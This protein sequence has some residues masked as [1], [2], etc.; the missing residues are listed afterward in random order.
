MSPVDT[1]TAVLLVVSRLLVQQTSTGSGPQ[2][3]HFREE[4]VV[5]PERGAEPR[6]EVAAAVSVLSRPEIE[7]LPAENLAE[8]LDFLPG[9]QVLFAQGFGLVPMVLSRGFFGGGEAEYVQLLIDGVPVADVESGIAD[10]RRVRAADVERV[11]ALRGPGSSL[12]GDA[13]LGGVVQ[14]FTRSAGTRPQGEVSLSAA[15]FDSLSL[16]ALYRGKPDP[17][18]LGFIGSVSRTDGFRRHSAADERS[19][20]ATLGSSPPGRRWSVSLSGSERARE[21]PGP[22]SLRQ[23]AADRFASDPLFRFDREK[24]RRGRAAFALGQ[25]QEQRSF[26]VLVHGTTR[27]T[28]FL[29]TLLIGA[30]VGDRAFRTISTDSVGASAEAERLLTAWGRQ[31][32]L[33]AG[34]DASHEWLRTTYSAV[35]E[36]GVRGSEIANGAGRRDRLAVFVSQDGRLH[37]RLRL[38][39]GLRWDR[40]QDESRP[41]L[42]R[43]HPAQA[44]SPRAGLNLRLGRADRPVL[45]FVQT[46]RAFK[47]ATLDQLL[48]PR[49]FPDF[50]GGTFRISNPTLSPQRAVTLEG[51]LSFRSESTRLEALVYRTSVKDEIDFD[52]STFR[53]NNIGRSRHSG[54]EASAWMGEGRSVSS[55]LSYVWTRV[56][57]LQEAGRGRQLKN[58]PRHLVRLGTTGRLPAGLRVEACLTWSAGRYLDDENR[59][60][61]RNASVVEL[62]LGRSFGR[63]RTRVDLMNL[64]GTE[65]EEVGYALPDFRGGSV[66]YF[67]P[68]AG[69]AVRLGLDWRFR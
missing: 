18:R 63:F 45:L 54:L 41:A 33:R 15:S 68:S 25:E 50:A 46:S 5:T 2:S 13:A 43:A 67:F 20:D 17:V 23:L 59:I 31:G 55:R 58:I 32:R 38:V 51:G 49:P 40:I 53:Y 44:F 28:D 35:S 29:R 37:P 56:E 7:R 30:G 52:P 22:L 14:V 69:R 12:Y 19:A 27:D 6:G 16:D 34:L 64:T 48:D 60:P 24:T 11:E 26:R 62:R 65:W 57:A 4:I 66:P 1:P 36:T 3:P 9:F 47:A 8:L 42:D 61:F 21:E 39:A 10:W